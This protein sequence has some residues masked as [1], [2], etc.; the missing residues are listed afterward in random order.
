MRRRRIFLMIPVCRLA[1]TRTPCAASPP[2]P[3]GRST[4]TRASAVGK[5]CKS[6]YPSTAAYGSVDGREGPS[7][8]M[9]G[10]MADAPWRV[11]CTSSLRPA[12]TMSRAIALAANREAR[13]TWTSA[14]VRG[15]S[16]PSIAGKVVSTSRRLGE[17]PRRLA[18]S[19]I[20]RQCSSS[21][22]TCLLIVLVMTV[23]P[24]SGDVCVDGAANIVLRQR[25]E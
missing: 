8:R 23:Q 15:H 2:P 14:W 5:W 6:S 21:T 20:R 19:S 4:A 16:G 1:F 7:G 22:R 25:N 18:A 11:S 10:T 3:S 17:S 12:F 13:A 9:S 24:F